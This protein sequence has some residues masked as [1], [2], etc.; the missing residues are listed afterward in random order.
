MKRVW[1]LV[2]AL[3]CLWTT[4]PVYASTAESTATTNGTFPDIQGHWAQS[5]VET[6]AGIKVF[7]GYPDGKF[8]PNRSLSR[9]EFI[10]SLHRAVDLGLHL[11]A[12]A[13]SQPISRFDDVPPDVWYAGDVDTAL[14]RGW[15]TAADYGADFHPNDPIPRKEMARIIARVA[16]QMKVTLPDVG[17][18]SFSDVP[19]TSAYYKDIESATRLGVL[20]GYP[21]GTFRPDGTLT[22]A[23]AA[24]VILNTLHLDMPKSPYAS[25]YSKWAWEA[26]KAADMFIYGGWEEAF[27][28]KSDAVDLSAFHSFVSGK[29]ISQYKAY[30]DFL[31]GLK[32]VGPSGYG[33]W[34][35]KFKPTYI[36]NNIALI[37]WYL[38]FDEKIEGAW[39]AQ[40]TEPFTIVVKR[41]ANRRWIVEDFPIT[42]PQIDQKNWPVQTEPTMNNF[43]SFQYTDK[44][45]DY[46][47]HVWAGTYQNPQLSD[48]EPVLNQMFSDAPGKIHILRIM[49]IPVEDTPF[50]A[51]VREM[52][53]NQT[54]KLMKAGE[55]HLVVDRTGN[56]FEFTNGDS[57][58]V[59]EKLWN[60]FN[61]NGGQY[62]ALS[63][64]GIPWTTM[65][66][67]PFWRKLQAYP[68]SQKVR[69]DAQQLSVA[70]ES[71]LE[72]YK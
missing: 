47:G 41:G 24:T 59:L 26:A 51:K 3:L 58:A 35:G 6:M 11:Q 45:G 15:I 40:K 2:I 7:Q 33:F 69:E 36:N 55:H 14:D 37:S 42:I 27:S 48:A 34:M 54:D 12:P 50:A 61:Y 57:T 39:Y 53:S 38:S 72:K 20:N 17:T 8:Y 25:A 71:V 67:D 30:L 19:Q 10:A 9:A 66:E 46:F 65:S 63:I 64:D 43:I 56:W 31:K 1:C 16:S 29:A 62:V 18:K 22:R 21:D 70:F 28:Q 49:G 4:A 23:E 60:D 52:E 13:A 44:S 5:T 68:S 32:D